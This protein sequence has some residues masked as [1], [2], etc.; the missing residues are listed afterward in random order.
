MI[1]KLKSKKII[2]ITASEDEFIKI[3]D[4][5]FNLVN[6]ISMRKLGHIDDVD[7]VKFLH[8]NSKKNTNFNQRKLMLR[9]KVSIFLLAKI[10]NM[11][12]IHLLM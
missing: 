2:I 1:I 5:K 6:Q 11:T 7:K 12:V 10:Q 4:T 3:W 9:L 8:I